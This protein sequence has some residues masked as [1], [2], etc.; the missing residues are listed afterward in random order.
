V[1]LSVKIP[2]QGTAAPALPWPYLRS[3]TLKLWR[4]GWRVLSSCRRGRQTRHMN[5]EQSPY[6]GCRYP[7]EIISHSVW[8]YP[9][10]YL[11]FRDVG[12]LLAERGIIVSYETISDVSCPCIRAVAGGDVGLLEA[13]RPGT[14]PNLAGRGQVDSTVT[15]PHTSGV[16]RSFHG[17]VLVY[18]LRA[19]TITSRVR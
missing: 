18:S 19:T 7:T 9:R 11:S 15:W 16:T 2:R 17:Q 12:D 5:T 13:P 14:P 8:L 4:G 3:R 10:F 1:T 6:R